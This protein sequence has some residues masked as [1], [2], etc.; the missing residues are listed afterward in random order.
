ME[1]LLY[2]TPVVQ[3]DYIFD[4]G[5]KCDMV[6]SIYYKSEDD[7]EFHDWF[8]KY[9]HPKGW[10]LTCGGPANPHSP[11]RNSKGEMYDKVYSIKRHYQKEK[12]KEGRLGHYKKT[13]IRLTS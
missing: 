6:G 12:G 1:M 4:C 3:G 11:E 10:T 8:K 2:T 9:M 13:V 5:F 7:K